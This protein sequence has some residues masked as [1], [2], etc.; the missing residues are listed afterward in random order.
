MNYKTLVQQQTQD[1]YMKKVAGDL[2]EKMRKLRQ[3]AHPSDVRR[4]IWELIQ[5]GKDV[6]SPGVPFHASINLSSETAPAVLEFK[7]NG[8]PFSVKN[9]TYLVEAVSSKDQ[10]E[11]EEGQ[12]P[13]GQFGSGFL[14]TH[15]LSPKVE[16]ETI[17]KADSLPYKKCLLELD[18]SATDV[19]GV[20][21]SMRSSLAILETLD[22][23]QDITDY[24]PHEFSTTFRYH[25]D[26]HSVEIAKIGLQD[27]VQS[28]IFTLVFVPVIKS[29]TIENYGITYRL[30]DELT[31]EKNGVT[32]FTVETIDGLGVPARQQIVSVMGKR[33]QI[34]M[35]VITSDGTL[36]FQKLD[37]TQPRL[38]CDFPMIG[39]E[40]FPFP[41]IANSSYYD[42]DDP[43]STII[44]SDVK[45][46]GI[47]ENKAL[48][49]EA[50]GLY[51]QLLRYCDG[52]KE[53][54]HIFNIA[55]TN[56]K[57][58]RDWLSDTWYK[59]EML[60][61][62][63]DALSSMA[64]VD[65]ASGEKVKID[66][67]EKTANVIFPAHVNAEVRK[68]LY[69]LGKQLWPHAMPR[70]TE[71][72]EWFDVLWP[73][74]YK[75]T[76]KSLSEFIANKGNITNLEE[77]LGEKCKIND[78]L[79]NYYDLLN[80]EEIYVADIVSNSIAVIPDQ[81]GQFRLMKDVK[82]DNG[83][84][85]VFK[86]VLKT[87]GYD[88]RHELRRN[89]LITKN[90][91]KEEPKYKIV[92]FT[93]KRENVYTALNQYLKEAPVGDI[94][95]P[96]AS[97]AAITTLQGNAPAWHQQL[98]G[99]MQRLFPDLPV[100]EVQV[101]EYSENI[102]EQASLVVVHHIL[103]K[104]SSLITLE[105][106][107]G[108]LGFKDTETALKFLS[109]FVSLLQQMGQ[110]HLVHTTDFP[111]LPNQHG[112]FRTKEELMGGPNT[113]ETL[114]DISALLGH[115][116]RKN[117]IDQSLLLTF[118]D[119]MTVTDTIIAEK[120]SS[121][122]GSLMADM[123][124]DEDTQKAFAKLFTWF[125]EKRTKAQLLFGDLYTNRHRLCEPDTIIT[126][127]EKAAD[128]DALLKENGVASVEDLRLILQ[129]NFGKPPQPDIS[130]ITKDILVN[131]GVKNYEEFKEALK[132]K[133][134]A[135][136]FGHV[137]VPS[138]E[139]FMFAESKIDRTQGQVKDFLIRLGYNF[140]MADSSTSNIFIGVLK[141]GRSIDIVCRPGDNNE[142]ILY[143]GAEIAHLKNQGAEL[144]VSK[145]TGDPIQLTI[146]KIVEDNDLKKI[147]FT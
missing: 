37:D 134:L 18:R 88:I 66:D 77:H 20:M 85:D 13:T 25:L 117:L 83:L 136:L 39:S 69:H 76:L 80:F 71:I 141:D 75:L 78:W 4:W 53:T 92:H 111:I 49:K 19:E 124:Q 42:L 115:D 104:I 106:F 1:G 103:E 44:L 113:D 56:A 31:K 70:E 110:E 10:E 61:P 16:L 26:A 35:P 123:R 15:L 38:F 27:L 96:A 114:K 86:D 62:V 54:Q 46:A 102:Y 17:I 74:C 144:W 87:L 120:I 63:L 3:G 119:A 29:I 95:Q 40:D 99:V 30:L 81:N 112:I 58:K 126:S 101:N 57:F 118:S 122:A 55:K 67:G 139:Y 138:V 129:N 32:F 65:L 64:I 14:T 105:N 33:T 45:E 91:Y 125:N 142:V 21:K 79:N 94:L 132:D 98:F 43:R 60:N 109:D 143:S 72:G 128:L 34:A 73:R 52:N 107:T 146:G 41:V 100:K 47:D 48:I 131:L 50:V 90:R 137:S 97:I 59:N 89:E 36:Y 2:K 9:I 147:R 82:F 11:Y 68:S 28:M 84:E 135:E 93:Y 116:Y 6:A 121:L 127:M 145:A 12:R 8:R 5:N 23:L 130:E 51:I 108:E 133:N 140:S 22:E 7:H 24:D